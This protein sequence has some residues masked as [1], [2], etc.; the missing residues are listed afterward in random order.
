MHCT[1]PQQK[2]MAKYFRTILVD[3]YVV[4]ENDPPYDYPTLNELKNKFII[5][6]TPLYRYFL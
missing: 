1:L 6:V 2:V 3:I 5:K 4:D